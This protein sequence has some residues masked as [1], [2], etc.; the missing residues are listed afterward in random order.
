MGHDKC[1]KCGG[2]AYKVCS[3]C[4]DKMLLQL[5]EVTAHRD[6]LRDMLNEIRGRANRDVFSSEP[7]N[8]AA[9]VLKI[10]EDGYTEKQNCE[11]DWQ[12]YILGTD[13]QCT[14]CKM[15][16]APESFR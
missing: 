16:K 15:L 9:L 11:H 7:S 1:S 6:R 4:Y 5:S 13:V 8:F 10:V 3:G 2:S 12:P 14:K